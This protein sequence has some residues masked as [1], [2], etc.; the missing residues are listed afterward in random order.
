M[1][2]NIDEETPGAAVG[3]N[4]PDIVE[5]TPTV[6]NTSNPE[7]QPRVLYKVPVQMKRYKEHFYEPEVV[8]LGPY[9]HRGHP[10]SQLVDPL[11]NELEVLLCKDP[12]RKSFLLGEI[13]KRIDEIR[14][15]YMGADAYDDEE[16]A[17]MMLRDACFLICNM[18]GGETS[19]LIGRRLGLS[20][21]LF[22]YRD[23]RMLENQIPLWL[24][25]LIHPDP[26]LLLCQYLNLIVFG[27]DIRPTQQNEGGAELLVFGGYT[28][29]TQLPW[30]NGKG[31]E[32]LHL[33][34]AWYRI[35]LYRNESPDKSRC[36]SQIIKSYFNQASAKK[37]SSITVWRMV[38]SPFR[39]ATDLRAKGIHFRRSSN[40][41]TDIKFFSCAFYAE[42]QLPSFY[43]T[44]SSKVYFSNLIS[45]EMSPK[46]DTDKDTVFGLTSYL[47]FMKALIHN[48]N[49][50]KVLREKGILYG[51]LA[52]DE[53][54]VEMF[55]SID[56]YGYPN[57]G[58]FLDVKMMI[59]EHCNNKARTWMADLMK[60]NF[61]SPWTI[62][63]LVAATFLLCL[64]FLQTYFTINPR[65]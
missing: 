33:L 22:M 55:K 24:I 25:S 47:N 46:R 11:K 61:R 63:A 13:R 2:G 44:N 62:I 21:K 26:Q 31:E 45:F 30:E 7:S 54:V 29:I 12:N 1:E 9:H 38:N 57:R 37:R 64:T 58:L 6:A 56:T 49:D 5:E 28:R 20:G 39:S 35:L 32:P 59:E 14:R 16:L 23:I 3:V 15:F 50:V 18:Q 52:T 40:C 43:V 51:L 17:E 10:Q 60:T 8:P 34:D 53:D 48:A 42:L 36:F 4:I 41:L 19:D 65:N 27:D